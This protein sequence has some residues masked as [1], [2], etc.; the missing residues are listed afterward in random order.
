MNIFRFA[1]VALLSLCLPA[2]AQVEAVGPGPVTPTSVGTATVGQ[3]PGTTTNDVAAA[4]KVGEY[5]SSNVPYASR[6]ALTNNTV[7]DITSISLTAGNWNVCGNV[8]WEV[9]ATTVVSSLIGYVNN[10]SVTLPSPPNNGAIWY[11]NST[12]D[13]N[14]FSIKG[15]TTGCMNVS[16]SGTTTYYLGTRA[17]FSVSTA[18]VYGFIGATRVR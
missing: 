4:G 13:A 17:L 2:M 6:I 12:I 7:A 14:T 1:A 11:D 15:G 9:D 8:F 18:N 10:A 5:I 16:L 3:I